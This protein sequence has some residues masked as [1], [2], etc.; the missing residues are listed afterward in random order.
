[1]KLYRLLAVLF[2]S[3]ST[4]QLWAQAPKAKLSG[5]IIDYLTKE[6]VDYSTISLHPIEDSKKVNGTIADGNGNF[7]LD[8]IVPGKYNISVNFIGYTER[9]FESYAI[10]PGENNLGAIE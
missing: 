10:K 7:E 9:R 1:M 5:K 8:N 4:A 6:I 2:L 3:L